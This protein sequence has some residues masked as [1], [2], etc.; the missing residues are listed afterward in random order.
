MSFGIIRHNPVGTVPEARYERL[1]RKHL[2]IEE[3]KKDEWHEGQ[4]K[5]S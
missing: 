3:A 5:S 4:Q 2:S 1:E